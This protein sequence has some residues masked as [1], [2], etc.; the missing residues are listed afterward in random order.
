MSGAQDRIDAGGTWVDWEGEPFVD[1]TTGR[2]GAFIDE[3]LELN[4]AEL[5][6]LCSYWEW[7][8]EQATR[9]IDVWWCWMVVR[10]GRSLLAVRRG[11]HPPPHRLTP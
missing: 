3:C 7:R 9:D 4:E 10:F 5:E 1:P 8:T 2:P 11:H 6:E